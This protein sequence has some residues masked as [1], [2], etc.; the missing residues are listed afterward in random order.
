MSLPTLNHQLADA[1]NAFRVAHHRD[2]LRLCSHLISSA[3]EHSLQMGRLGY[4]SHSSANGTPF[5]RRIEHYYSPRNYS[6]WAAG[7][8]LLWA[9]RSMS[10]GSALRMWITSPAHRQNLLSRQW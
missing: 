6:Y 10:A 9:A 4:F 5:W 7:E 2:R 3:R 8:N 1:V